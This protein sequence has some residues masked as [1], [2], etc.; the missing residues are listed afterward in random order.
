MAKTCIPHKKLE[1]TLGSCVTE[2]PYSALVLMEIINSSKSTRR[3]R[4]VQINKGH[5]TQIE[6]NDFPRGLV[7]PPI[8][9]RNRG[10]A[11]TATRA[12]LPALCMAACSLHDWDIWP[13]QWSV[14]HNLAPVTNFSPE[15]VG[16]PLLDV[17]V[18]KIP[19]FASLDPVAL[20]A[21]LPSLLIIPKL[22]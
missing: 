8:L 11:G 19:A 12:S 5:K 1:K 3:K 2:V 10:M 4:N 21:E 18:E 15:I 9:L 7:V 16:P 17:A 6:V 13:L 14:L 20:R 22:L